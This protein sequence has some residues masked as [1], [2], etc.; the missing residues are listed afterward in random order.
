MILTGD[1]TLDLSFV[2]LHLYED[3]RHM[4]ILLSPI[5]HLGRAMAQ[6]VS[7]WLLTMKAQFQSQASS[8]G[9]CCG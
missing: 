9:I 5:Y 6:V 8:C 4:R 2:L 1:V 7:Y 3:S